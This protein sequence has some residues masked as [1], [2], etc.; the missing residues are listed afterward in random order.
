MKTEGLVIAAQDHSPPTKNYPANI[1]NTDQTLYV[2]CENKKTKKQKTKKNK[3]K[4]KTQ[5][6]IIWL[7]SVLLPNPNTDR[8]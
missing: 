5:K 2:D 4:K 1:K 3:T 7:L 6:K 8:I